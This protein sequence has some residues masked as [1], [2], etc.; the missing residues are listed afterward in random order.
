MPVPLLDLKRQFAA[1]SSEIRA[2]IDEVIDAQAFILGRPVE[3]LEAA[4]AAFLGVDHAVGVASGTDALLLPLK[5]LELQP[6]DEVITSP[7][8]FFATAG[9]IHNAGG[10]PVFV[11]IEPES[12][13]LDPDRVEQAVTPRTRAIVPVHLFGQMAEMAP[14]REIADRHGLPLIEDAAQ[15][16]GARQRV[17]DEWY[18]TGRLGTCAAFSFFPSKNL[19]AF[20]DGG[21]IVTD[22]AALAA[23]LRRLRVHGGLKM[24]HHEEVGTNSRLDAL[25]AAVLLAKLPHLPAWSEARRRNAAAYNDRLADLERRGCIERPRVREHNESIF[26]QYTLRARNRDGLRD[27]LRAS[28]IGNAVYYPVPLHLQPCFAYLGYA[29]GAFPESERAAREVVSIPVFPELTAD[30]REEVAAA[31][32]AFYEGQP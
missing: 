8:T 14:L 29:E 18:A 9:A 13:N 25:Q 32:E 11:D 24:Y 31:I 7:F 3:E 12:F 19:G 4:V 17:G 1:I 22:D 15:A 28:G 27:H 10:R 23:R 2:R 5:A 16:I 20:G 21:M 6:G 30:E 26:N